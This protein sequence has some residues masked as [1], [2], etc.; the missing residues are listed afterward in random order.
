MFL[1]T[2]FGVRHGTGIITR[3]TGIPGNP[4]TGIIITDIIRITTIIIM[5][6]IVIV[7]TTAIP[8][9]MIITTMAIARIQTRCTST[10]KVECTKILI[11]VLKHGA[12]VQLIS[13]KN[14]LT[15]IVRLPDQE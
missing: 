10:G 1:H 12:R 7:I 5:V 9:T 2:Q 8:I 15:G 13:T 14:I 3:H 11:P 6:I 4:I